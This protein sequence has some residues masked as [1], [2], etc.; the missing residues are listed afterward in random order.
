MIESRLLFLLV[1]KYMYIIVLW[2]LSAN[3]IIMMKYSKC[4]L[5]P[6]PGH[7]ISIKKPTPFL[8]QGYQ[9]IMDGHSAH[10]KIFFFFATNLFLIRTQNYNN[11]K[12]A[13]TFRYKKYPKTQLRIINTFVN[14]VPLF[15]AQSP[16]STSKIFQVLKSSPKIIF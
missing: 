4:L 13:V 1:S 5:C 15:W 2:L 9:P 8:I 3:M 14:C 6:L 11:Y 12:K 16:F 10:F 7:L